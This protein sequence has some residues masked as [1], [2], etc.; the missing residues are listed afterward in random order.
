MRT[1]ISPVRAAGPGSVHTFLRFALHLSPGDAAAL[2]GR[3]QAVIDEYAASDDQRLEQ[4]TYGGVVVLH[5]LRVDPDSTP[6]DPG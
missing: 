6:T 3:L 2:H 5:E 4:P 1:P